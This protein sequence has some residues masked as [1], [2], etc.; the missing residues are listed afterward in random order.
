ML[1]DPAFGAAAALA[2]LAAL[3]PTGLNVLTA[4]QVATATYD[5]FGFEAAAITVMAT[6]TGARPTRPGRHLQL[7]FARP[8]AVVAVLGTVPPAQSTSSPS[9][10]VGLPMFDAWVTHA[11]EPEQARP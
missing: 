6:F 7:R 4:R 2:A 5:R 9:R 8:F 11:M 10:Y 1:A 3:L